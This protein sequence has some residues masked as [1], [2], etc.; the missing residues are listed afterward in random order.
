M[1]S[2]WSHGTSMALRDL[3]GLRRIREIGDS[4]G[5]DPGKRLDRESLEYF[6]EA[7]RVIAEEER[8]RKAEE[9]RKRMRKRPPYSIALKVQVAVWRVSACY[10]RC[11][12]PGPH[13]SRLSCVLVIH[14]SS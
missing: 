2:T 10:S 14:Q 9:A 8:L 3:E 7:R 11:V 1:A 13:P 12:M 4:A 6:A 5:L